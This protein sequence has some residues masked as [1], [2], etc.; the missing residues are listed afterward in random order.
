MSVKETIGQDLIIQKNN[1]LKE[2]CE[3]K[4]VSGTEE[5]VIEKERKIASLEADIRD[6]TTKAIE[7]PAKKTDKP[8]VKAG[9]LKTKTEKKASSNNK[10]APK[11]ATKISREEQVKKI[12]DKKPSITNKEL[13]ERTGINPG[14]IG[15]V[16][17]KVLAK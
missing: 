1:L 12:L 13:C 3:L 2:V 4:K 9:V 6:L 7:K 16:R 14:Y 17:A 15:R 11:K 5:V 10:N 8:V